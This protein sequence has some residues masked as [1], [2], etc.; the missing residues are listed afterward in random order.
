MALLDQ[1]FGGLMDRPG[2]EASPI[3]AILVNMFGCQAA[4]LGYRNILIW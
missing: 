3:Q 1:G 2:S 4:R